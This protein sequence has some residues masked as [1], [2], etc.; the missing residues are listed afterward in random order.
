VATKP[1][2]WDC[3]MILQRRLERARRAGREIYI[4]APRPFLL[5]I[6]D[7]LL[8]GKSHYGDGLYE[9][10]AEVV[11]VDK[12][13]LMNLKSISDKFQIS[14]RCENLSWCHHRELASLKTLEKKNASKEEKNSP[15]SYDTAPSP[16]YNRE[17]TRLAK[18]ADATTG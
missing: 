9:K 4:P 10:A 12:P 6:G 8:D 13:Q 17:R 2:P 5:A 18:E 7:W 3:I 14:Q 15:V 11:G 16:D 1:S